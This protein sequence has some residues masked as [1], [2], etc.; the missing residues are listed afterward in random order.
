MFLKT[1]RGVYDWKDVAAMC[2][3]LWVNICGAQPPYMKKLPN[4]DFATAMEIEDS[5]VGPTNVS[6]GNG[7]VMDFRFDKDIRETNSAWFKFTVDR[8]TLLSFDIVPLDSADDYD[9]IVFK[10][11]DKKC[12]ENIRMKKVLPDRACYSYHPSKSGIT[13]LSEY[14]SKTIIGPGPGVA[15]CAALPVKAGETYY[16]MIDNSFG[17][18]NPL[19]MKFPKGF[20]IYFYNYWPKKKAV[21]LNNV[22]FESNKAVLL[23]SSFTELDKLVA[24]LKANKSMKIEIR[25]HTDNEGNEIQNQKLSEARAKAVA[26]YIISK[27]I[28]RQ[29]IFYKGFGSKSPIAPNDTAEG[30]KKNRR[31]EFAIV[32]R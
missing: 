18:F 4:A 3:L 1:K 11:P 2:I 22:L 23:N 30:R 8:D 29:R 14:E 27:N 7:T 32:I 28:D 10:C 25:G 17:E 6:L 13:G 31:V 24:Q 21:V 26:D 15:Y 9:F 20:T 5:I 16:L 12:I 19:P